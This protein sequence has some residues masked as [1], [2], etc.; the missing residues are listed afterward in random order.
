MLKNSFDI[1]H[2]EK[3]FQEILYLNIEVHL[4]IAFINF[5]ILKTIILTMNPLTQTRNIMK[6]NDRELELGVAGTKNS[7]HNEYKVSCCI[8]L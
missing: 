8:S 6:M 5:Q 7:W 3:C 4:P 1:V 2:R